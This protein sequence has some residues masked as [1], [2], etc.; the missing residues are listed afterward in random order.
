MYL[1]ETL[2]VVLSLLPLAYLILQSEKTGKIILLGTTVDEFL[3]IS[4]FRYISS[5]NSLVPGFLRM[6]DQH[7]NLK[8][9]SVHPV[10]SGWKHAKKKKRCIDII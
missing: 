4:V 7:L 6:P 8:F 10:S 9:R 2:H 5:S 3:N 1:S